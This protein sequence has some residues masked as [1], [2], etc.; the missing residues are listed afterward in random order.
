MGE[1]ETML[2]LFVATFSLLISSVGIFADILLNFTDI[3][4]WL[5]SIYTYKLRYK[6]FEI[7]SCERL[8]INGAGAQ[9]IGINYG[10]LGNNLPSLNKVAGTSFRYITASNEVIP[11]ELVSC[12]LPAMQNLDTALTDSKLN[13]PIS[14]VIATDVLGV[15]FPPS[16]GV[17]SEALSTDMTGI[18]GFLVSKKTPLFVNVY[19]YFAYANQPK[20]MQLNYALFIANGMVV[21][22]SSLN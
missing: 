16:Q 15:L 18:A 21:I 8:M 9:G 2:N 13:I 10:L 12:V 1:M 22:D 17:F 14:T 5:A 3:G 7:S 11:G 20:D 19:P 4:I 6:I